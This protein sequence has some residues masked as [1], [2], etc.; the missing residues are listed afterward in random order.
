MEH[1]AIVLYSVYLH[2]RSKSAKARESCR[3]ERE[4]CLELD[5]NIIIKL[6]RFTVETFGDVHVHWFLRIHCELKLFVWLES[7][8]VLEVYPLRTVNIDLVAVTPI[9]EF[10]LF[11]A[12]SSFVSVVALALSCPETRTMAVAVVHVLAHHRSGFADCLVFKMAY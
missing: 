10:Y 6:R 3:W 1:V 2:C 7:S 5:L 12:I 9:K 11:R 8:F 4:S